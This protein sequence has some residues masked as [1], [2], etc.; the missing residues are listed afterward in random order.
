MAK[1]RKPKRQTIKTDFDPARSPT[2]EARKLSDPCF[3]A[4]I[5]PGANSYNRNR[6]KNNGGKG[7]G[8]EY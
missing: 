5:L 2:P 1:K 6:D 7:W 3:R 4:R 8:C